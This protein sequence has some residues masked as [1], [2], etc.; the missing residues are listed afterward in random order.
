MY[1]TLMCVPETIADV[2]K[3]KVLQ[4]PSVCL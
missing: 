4:I 3:Q 2:E 1:V